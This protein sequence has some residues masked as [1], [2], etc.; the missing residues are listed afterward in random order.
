M[1][2]FAGSI[3]STGS[4]WKA[5]PERRMTSASNPLWAVKV[6]A[7]SRLIFAW[8]ADDVLVFRAASLVEIF[9]EARASP[10][11]LPIS[12][13]EAADLSDKLELY[14][15]RRRRMFILAHMNADGGEAVWSWTNP[16]WGN[17]SKRPLTTS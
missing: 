5:K 7:Q 6:D 2:D 1:I 10:K 13:K 12:S 15:E 14:S 4:A 11:S 17:R 3:E 8:L 9:H 16:K